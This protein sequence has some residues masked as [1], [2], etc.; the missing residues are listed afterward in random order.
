M[1]PGLS[2]ETT[3]KVLKDIGITDKDIDVYI[4][5]A[6]HGVLKGGEITSQTKTHKALI[7]RILKSLQ[8]KGLVES[9]LEFPAR[10]TAVPF[11]RVIDLNIK[12]KHDEADKIE[13]QKIELLNYWQSI[14]KTG[15]E[16]SLEKFT[17][18]N[19]NH[20]I[21]HKLSQMIKDTKNQLSTVSTVQGLVRADQF[22]L[23]D[24]KPDQNLKSDIKFR[25]LT[26]L[27]S[28]NLSALKEL[29]N[30]KADSKLNIEARIPE[31]GPGIYFHK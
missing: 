2:E 12:L 23:F 6:K 30:V 15:T 24:V 1:R 19:G 31:T 7:Y 22:G 18:I 26:E 10:F 20:K 16:I 5:L 11:E 14:K 21:Y 29:L 17:V 25:F 13:Q 9:T 28:Q 4:F 27:S 8:S 3:R